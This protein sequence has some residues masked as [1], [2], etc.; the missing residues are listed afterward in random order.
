[1]RETKRITEIAIL[2]SLAIVI[3]LV[4]KFIPSLPQGGSINVATLPLFVLAYRH[5]IKWGVI[6]GFVYGLLSYMLFGAFYHWASILLDYGLAF[7]VIGFSG[8]FRYFG[9][10]N[11]WSF[12]A[13][14]VFGSFLRFIMHTI[15]GVIV[16]SFLLGYNEDVNA[17]WY[18]I[19]YNAT[20]ILPSMILV[21]IVGLAVFKPIQ[22]IAEPTR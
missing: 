10:D 20:Y 5:G 19:S 16:F 13:G 8:I 17:Y 18:S 12:S 6:S 3:E 4:S 7:G 14:V 11:I 21:L 9:K 22:M 2:V 1:M 15:S